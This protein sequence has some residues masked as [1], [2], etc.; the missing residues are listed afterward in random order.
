M[1]S[2]GPLFLSWVDKEERLN[3]GGGEPT[4]LP[5]ISNK[6]GEPFWQKIN[7]KIGG[8]GASKG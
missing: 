7:Y 1:K 6:R 5:T 4:G 2:R 3:D 8:G